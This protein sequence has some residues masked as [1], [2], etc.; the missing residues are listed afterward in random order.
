MSINLLFITLNLN[1]FCKYNEKIIQ[2][3]FV[4]LFEL[5]CIVNILIQGII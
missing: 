3:P 4:T 5:K 2:I 1:F